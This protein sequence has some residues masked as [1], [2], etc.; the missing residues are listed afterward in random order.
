M[1]FKSGLKGDGEDFG[2]C[3]ILAGV[4]RWS[5]TSHQ[6]SVATLET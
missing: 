3:R 2:L 1:G 5:S 6:G 4:S